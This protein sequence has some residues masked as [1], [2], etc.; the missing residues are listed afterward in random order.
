VT[1][2]PEKDVLNKKNQMWIAVAAGLGIGLALVLSYVVASGIK[3][4]PLFSGSTSGSTQEQFASEAQTS[5]QLQSECQ[6]SAEKIT[7]Y[8]DPIEA[9]SVVKMFTEYKQNAENCRN[10]YFSIEKKSSISSIPSI[11]SEGTYPDLIIDITLLA[12]KTNKKQAIEMLNFAKSLSPWE[13]YWGSVLCSSK[14]T[15]EAY[16]E[17][18]TLSDEKICFK[19][20]TDREKLFS[21]IKNKNFSIFSTS[22][23]Y[24]RVVLLGSTNSESACP[25]K[26]STVTKLVH[27]IS[28]ENVIVEE[29]KVTPPDNKRMNFIFKTDSESKL[30]LKF[31]ALND[32]LQL[33]SVLIPEQQVNE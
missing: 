32:C 30:V 3:R 4:E 26:I 6:K 22:L 2:T 9:A 19:P 21:E 13:Y 10:V 16:S 7:S 29:E 20:D 27:R 18:L 12:A 5:E 11:R 25:E 24:E 8:S 33:H 31:L 23:K 17:V 15:L 28:S 14:T 1:S